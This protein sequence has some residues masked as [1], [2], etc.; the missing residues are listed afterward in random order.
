LDSP[1]RNIHE[2]LAQYPHFVASADRPGAA[3]LREQVTIPATVIVPK[4]VKLIVK[5]G[6]DITVSPRASVV[7][8]GGLEAMG[9]AEQPI[10]VHGN[11]SRDAWGVFAAVEPKGAVKLRHVIFS[12]ANQAQVNGIVF[13]GGVA[14]YNGDLIVEQCQFLDMKSEDA[15]NLRNGRIAMSD[16]HFSGNAADSCDLDLVVGMIER[17][18]FTKSGHDGLECSGSSITVTDCRFEQ[19]GDKGCSIGEK[20]QPKLVNCLFLNN[21]IGTSTKDSSVAKM[22]FCSFVGNH[23]AIEALR[24]KPF[25]DGGAGD[26]V[27]CV[28]AK[29]ELTVTEDYFSRGKVRLFTSLLDVPPQYATCLTAV[30]EF[31]SLESGDY[32]LAQPESAIGPVRVVMPAWFHTI[33]VPEGVSSPGI[34]VCPNS[35]G[36]SPGNSPRQVRPRA[37]AKRDTDSR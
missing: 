33:D 36:E 16:C 30:I 28:F 29:N 21:L 22:A 19:N 11:V 26:F 27:N 12:D 6:T 2:F 14:V 31:Q 25:Y 3:E 8:Y 9:T 35:S 20:A 4:S 37:R 7:C 24:K 15:L 10:R 23:V 18:Y 34:Y 1:Q 5:P 17:S 13:S 32:R